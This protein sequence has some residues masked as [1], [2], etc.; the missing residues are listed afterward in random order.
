MRHLTLEKKIARLPD[1]MKLKLEE[2][3]DTLIEEADK[4]HLHDAKS[5]RIFGG[6]KGIFGNMADDF[7]EPLDDLKDYM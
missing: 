4:M 5:H 2:Y 3:V 1:V 6:G 7:N